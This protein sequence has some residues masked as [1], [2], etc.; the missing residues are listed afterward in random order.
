MVLFLCVA[1]WQPSQRAILL[2]HRVAGFVKRKVRKK[3]HKKDPEILCNLLIA[4]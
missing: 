2:Y 1:R 3:L 4:F